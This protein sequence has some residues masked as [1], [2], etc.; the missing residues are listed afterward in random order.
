MSDAPAAGLS[1]SE[2]LDR[3]EALYDGAVRALRTAI[4]DF[5]N[6]GTLPDA[7]A[8]ANGLFVYPELRITWDGLSQKHSKTRAYGRLTH[9]G[10][11]RTTVTR[12]QLFRH[13]LAEQ[14]A[15]LENDYSATID[16]A[17]SDKEIPYPYVI[18]GAN[19]KLERSMSA[20]LAQH[21]PTTSLALIG[22]ETAD[23]LLQ[24]LD[25]SPLSHFDALRTDFSLW[26]ACATTP[27]PAPSTS[28][29]LCCLPTIPV[30]LMNSCAGLVIRLPI[31]PARTGHW[32]AQAAQ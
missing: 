13:Y 11:Y 1:A 8:R 32:P 3:L 15:I 6:H 29:R 28:S 27:A 12:P 23:G 18:D 31:P 5:I 16:V 21:F 17:P 19:L 30:M 2:A 26:H 4:G 24:T 14:L 9:G 10:S 7:A 25:H 20:A 22:D